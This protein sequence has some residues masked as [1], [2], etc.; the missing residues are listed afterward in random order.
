LNFISDIAA[1]SGLAYSGFPD[2]IFVSDGKD[3]RRA[4]NISA[5]RAG[6]QYSDFPTGDRSDADIYGRQTNLVRLFSDRAGS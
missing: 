1:F 6:K 5:M 2:G 3:L 4:D